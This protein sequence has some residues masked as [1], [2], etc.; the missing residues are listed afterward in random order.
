MTT[1]FNSISRLNAPDPMAQFLDAADPIYGTGVDGNVVL[2]GSTTILGMEPAS[3]KYTMT[4]DLYFHNLTLNTDIHLQTNGYRLFVKNQLNMANGSR[5]GFTTGFSTAGSI[6]QGGG[7]AEAVTNSLGGAGLINDIATMVETAVTATAPI[8]ELGG[9]KYY[10]TPHQA[11]KGWAATASATTPTF[12]RGGAGGSDAGG[13]VVI[14]AARY[15]TV[16]SG[17]ATISAPG[18]AIAG[19]G[20]GVVLIVS[21]HSA[22]PA[23]LSTDVTGQ[24]PGTV[25]YMQLV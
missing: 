3:S 9:A 16:T 5:I 22:L 8:A 12:L 19:A 24:N 14:I 2:D 21:S 25:N 17:T 15:I 18:G 20:G 10:T 4:S 6:A 7:I 1:S 23:G 13:G 11:I